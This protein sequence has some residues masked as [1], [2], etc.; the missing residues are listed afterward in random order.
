MLRLIRRLSRRIF[1][2][3]NAAVKHDVRRLSRRIFARSNASVKHD[4]LVLGH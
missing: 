4:V 3:S 2:R 1:A